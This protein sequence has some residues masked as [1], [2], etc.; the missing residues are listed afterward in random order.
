M[1]LTLAGGS[2]WRKLMSDCGYK[3][4]TCKICHPLFLSSSPCVRK[5]T[6]LTHERIGCALCL[7]SR[8]Y[9]RQRKSF[10]RVLV[11]VCTSAFASRG[12]WTSLMWWILGS[13]CSLL[14]LEE[15]RVW[16][17]CVWLTEGAKCTLRELIA[18][19]MSRMLYFSKKVEKWAP[20]TRG[21]RSRGC[22]GS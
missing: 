19:S 18:L 6:C 5:H 3:R 22:R 7:H 17:E 1:N 11:S 13:F 15:F 21:F 9:Y 16:T 10:T 4:S 12:N 2:P 20:P 14:I 8:G